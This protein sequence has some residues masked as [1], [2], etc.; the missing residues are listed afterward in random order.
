MSDRMN[1]KADT[2]TN[3]DEAMEVPG[4]DT[5][6]ND[7]PAPDAR[8]DGMED[9]DVDP[10]VPAPTMDESEPGEDG[11]SQDISTM[12]DGEDGD[13]PAPEDLYK[14]ARDVTKHQVT[15]ADEVVADQYSYPRVGTGF[16]LG[17]TE[18]WQK[19][20]E[21]QNPTYSFRDGT[22]YGKR[23]MLASAIRFEAIMKEP[24]TTLIA[25][26][27]NS[28]WSGSF[29]NWNDDYSK[30]GW[31]DGRSA[32]LWAWRTTLVKWISQTNKDGS[33]FLPTLDMVEKLAENCASYAARSEGAIQGCSA[34]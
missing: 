32:R 3:M 31:G 34:P 33:C 30:S 25:L 11:D 14:D 7:M 17:G 29:F 12:M 24:P 19:W 1:G 21:G 5:S 18:F 23:C 8:P 13:M 26:K 15:F 10:T 16:S 6:P 9:G 20:P 2:T 28:D 22:P 4:D 27:E